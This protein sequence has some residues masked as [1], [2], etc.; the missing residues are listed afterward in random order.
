MSEL[1]LVAAELAPQL[2]EHFLAEL[3]ASDV[4]EALLAA[5]GQN[6]LQ[7]RPPI[8]IFQLIQQ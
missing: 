2:F 4:E 7:H 3:L 5:E 8:H 6:H 1:L